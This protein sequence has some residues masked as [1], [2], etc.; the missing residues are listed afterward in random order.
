MMT[1]TPFVKSPDVRLRTGNRQTLKKVR[2]EEQEDK[3]EKDCLGL[4]KA[5]DWE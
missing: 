5:C 1:M 3:E 4:P 2:F